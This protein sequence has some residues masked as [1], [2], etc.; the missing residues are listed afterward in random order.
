M[1]ERLEWFE[2]GVIKVNETL[3]IQSKT[4]LCPQNLPNPVRMSMFA[5]H[6][7]NLL[8]QNLSDLKEQD[9]IIINFYGKLVEEAAETTSRGDDRVDYYNIIIDW[10]RKNIINKNIENH[11]KSLV[12]LCYN[13]SMA[14]RISKKREIDNETKNEYA[15]L[16]IDR[17][18]LISD[19]EDITNNDDFK[20]LFEKKIYRNVDSF[21]GNRY[22]DWDK[23]NEI[24]NIFQK[25]SP[26]NPEVA[27]NLLYKEYRDCDW[28]IDITKE[29]MRYLK[30]KTLNNKFV[31]LNEG[32]S[33]AKKSDKTIKISKVIQR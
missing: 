29:C 28:D 22:L 18:Q 11:L 23:I 31:E 15:Q 27:I 1:G 7:K 8:T 25:E 6:N 10:S 32:S 21:I 3:N 14:T 5:E 19:I 24:T 9:K 2:S 12:D 16:I 17:K 13:E 33:M 30:M 20:F 4:E 26:R